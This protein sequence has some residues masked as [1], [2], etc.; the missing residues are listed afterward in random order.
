MEKLYFHSIYVVFNV[1]FELRHNYAIINSH[2]LTD[3]LIKQNEELLKVLKY[4]YESQ[5]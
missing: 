4:E 2:A 1:R 5:N 3:D